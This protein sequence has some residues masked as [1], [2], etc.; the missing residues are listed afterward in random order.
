MCHVEN[1]SQEIKNIKKWI[2]REKNW[3]WLITLISFTKNAKLII[4]F[5]WKSFISMSLQLSLQFFRSQGS[6]SKISTTLHG[7]QRTCEFFFN[8]DFHTFNLSC[9]CGFLLKK[10]SEK[11]E[12]VFFVFIK[13]TFMHIWSKR[14]RRKA[15]CSYLPTWAASIISKWPGSKSWRFCF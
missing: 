4:F 8:H 6:K 14:K 5:L 11:F 1:M 2:S 10:Q 12:R 13:E 3:S 7:A 15:L 9:N